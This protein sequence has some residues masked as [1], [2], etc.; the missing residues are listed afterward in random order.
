MLR[1]LGVAFLTFV[2]ASA[3]LIGAGYLAEKRARTFSES[4]V[5]EIF[6]EWNYEA[7]RRSSMKR[8]RE[9]PRMN[10]DGPKG[11]QWGKDG[12]GPLQSAEKPHGGVAISW[13]SFDD[14][15]WFSGQYDFIGHF[16]NGQAD[17]EISVVW[18]DRAW[19]ISNYRFHSSALHELPSEKR[20]A[21]K[22]LER[23]P[24]G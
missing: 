2:I 1:V 12:L 8:L 18:E 23:T 22:S 15:H 16:K 11:L 4:A 17:L 14:P 10:A 3:V 20:P 13:G 6:T 9:S 19:R 21:N 24:G 7:V 5:R